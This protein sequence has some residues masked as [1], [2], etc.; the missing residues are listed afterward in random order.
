MS[1][2]AS[3]ALKAWR[4]VTWRVRRGAGA[5]VETVC[6]KRKASRMALS[7]LQDVSRRRRISGAS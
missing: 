3:E 2:E 5:K 4:G 6:E 7:R 1:S